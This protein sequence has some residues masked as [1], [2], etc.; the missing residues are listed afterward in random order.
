MIM[1]K[2]KKEIRK[3]D[4]MPLDIYTK[5]RKELR[6]NIVEFKKN[7]RVSLGPYATFYFESYENN[8]SSSSRN[9]LHRKRRRRAV[10]R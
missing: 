2:E 6:K 10:K 3:D 8:A 9:A 7:R 1:P 5:Q 4:I